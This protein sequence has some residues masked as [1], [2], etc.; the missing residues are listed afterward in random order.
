MIMANAKMIE[1]KIR[2]FAAIG[3][4]LTV[5]TAFIANYIF[6]L[7]YEIL[8]YFKFPS[9]NQYIGSLFCLAGVFVLKDQITNSKDKNSSPA[10]DDD[11]DKSVTGESTADVGPIRSQSV[12]SV[13]LELSPLN[14][15]KNQINIGGIG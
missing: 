3:A 2:S 8:L 13:S 11:S 12:V 14:K 6:N 5:V 4:S 15:A 7:L 1:F 9:M 10:K